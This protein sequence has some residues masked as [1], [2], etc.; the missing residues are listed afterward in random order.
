MLQYLETPQPTVKVLNY[1]KKI[2]NSQRNPLAVRPTVV[3]KIINYLGTK[4]D[5]NLPK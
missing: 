1:L 3:E 4:P 2:S 5:F